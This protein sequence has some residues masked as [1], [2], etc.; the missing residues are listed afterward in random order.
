MKILNYQI[1]LLF[2]LLFITTISAQEF[3]K[4]GNKSGMVEYKLSGDAS[5]SSQTY[6]DDWGRKE[7]QIQNTKT[8]VWG[9]TTVEDKTTLM[10]GSDIYT[11]KKGETQIQKSVNPVARVWEEKNYDEKDID[12]FSKKSLESLGYK[13]TG[14]ETFDG[15]DCDVY[16]GL[17]G[18]LWIW[19]KNKIA[20][21]FNVNILGINI[22]SEASKIKLD[23]SIDASLFEIPKEME[24]V[25]VKSTNDQDSAEY[26]NVQN[27]I[28]NIF[29]N[30]SSK[31]KDVSATDKDSVSAKSDENFTEELIE[32]GKDAAVEGAK[33][34]AKETVKETAKE[35]AKKAT[36]KT[37]KGL[38]KSLW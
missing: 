24:I 26:E 25:S 4:Y 13:K 11:W 29:K 32:T 21:K 15:K 2:T 7:V 22:V 20:V 10:L 14:E 19:K 30:N 1:L 16:D 31:G 5:G 17:G 38:L 12:S 33:E 34:G 6:W 36:K 8:T 27:K 23:E 35:E 18:K 3:R 28:K 37:V 9:M